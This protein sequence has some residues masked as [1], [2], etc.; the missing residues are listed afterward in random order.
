M[1]WYSI[2]YVWVIWFQFWKIHSCS[3]SYLARR[4][5]ARDCSVNPLYNINVQGSKINQ[6]AFFIVDWTILSVLPW[7]SGSAGDYMKYDIRAY[8]SVL[9]W[10]CSWCQFFNGIRRWLTSV[11]AVINT[12]EARILNLMVTFQKNVKRLLWHAETYPLNNY[13]GRFSFARTHLIRFVVPCEDWEDRGVDSLW[14]ATG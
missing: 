9:I 10:C 13:Y 12:H 8:I 7:L 5:L 11:D 1:V 6:C 14:V 4:N 3:V 2:C